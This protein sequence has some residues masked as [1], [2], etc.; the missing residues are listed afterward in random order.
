MYYLIT[1]LR[2]WWCK[3]NFKYAMRISSEGQQFRVY[4]CE[5][6]FS[7]KYVK[8]LES[9]IEEAEFKDLGRS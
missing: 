6:C 2:Q 4:E 1:L 7:V 8:I 3:H 9:E 5:H